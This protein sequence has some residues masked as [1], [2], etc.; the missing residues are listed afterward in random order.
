MP[1]V[2]GDDATVR[3]RSVVDDGVDRVE[4]GVPTI[5]KKK[6]FASRVS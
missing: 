6:T 3:F 5:N 1:A 2:S 4:I